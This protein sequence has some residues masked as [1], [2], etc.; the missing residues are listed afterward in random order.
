[1]KLGVLSYARTASTLLLGTLAKYLQDHHGHEEWQTLDEVFNPS[2]D[3]WIIE[4]GDH[5]QLIPIVRGSVAEPLLREQRLALMKK[6]QHQ[7]YVIK[8]LGQD[9]MMHSG[10]GVHEFLK[11]TGYEFVS[12]ERRNPLNAILSA[13]VA[14][15]HRYWND[16]GTARL[17]EYHE[18]DAAMSFVEFVGDTIVQHRHA[19][20]MVPVR[21]ELFFEDVITM[22]RREILWAAGFMSD[23]DDTPPATKKLLGTDNTTLIKNI[24]EVREYYESHVVPHLN[25]QS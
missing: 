19:K 10:H 21:A 7:D 12:I 22:S 8:V 11:G 16:D 15:E 18:F 17:P 4:T 24:D 20:K 14:Y 23:E 2:D 5:L 6:Y 3:N 25:T 9:F 1:M 13:L